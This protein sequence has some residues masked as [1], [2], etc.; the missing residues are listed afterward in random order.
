ME[1]EARGTG[2]GPTPGHP[3][4]IADGSGSR[5]EGETRADTKPSD[6]WD[7]SPFSILVP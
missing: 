6:K 5:R 1:V 3:G 7:V 4:Q 2:Q